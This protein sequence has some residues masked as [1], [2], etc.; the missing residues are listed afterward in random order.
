MEIS[1]Y[2]GSLDAHQVTGNTVD[3]WLEESDVREGGDEGVENFPAHAGDDHG[4]E[5]GGPAVPEDAGSVQG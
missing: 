2:S 5:D 4:G 3:D 1:G